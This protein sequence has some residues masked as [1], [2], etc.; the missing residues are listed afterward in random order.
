MRK[1]LVSGLAAFVGLSVPASP[2][3]AAVFSRTGPVIAIVAG[4]IYHGEAEGSLGGTGTITIQSQA[5]PGLSCRGEFTY[6]AE[7]GD[8]GT[9]L[10]N[11]GATATFQFQR[12]S[13][14]RGHG[15]GKSTRGPMS[16]TYGLNAADSLPYLTPPRGKLLQL[17]GKDLV[18][19][20]GGAAAPAAPSEGAAPDV[21]LSAATVAV[22]AGLKEDR[23]LPKRNPAKIAQLVESTILPLFN[24]NHMTQLAVARN[25]RVAS[26]AQQTA[27]VAEFRTLLV[28]TYSNA[29]ENYRDQAVEYRPLHLAAGET[30]VTVKSSV[31]Q[32]GAE[33]LTIDYDMEKTAAGWKVYDIKIAGI[34][35]ITTYQSMF[36]Q[37]VRDEGVEGLIKSL[38][39]KNRQAAA[40]RS[41]AAA[42]RLAA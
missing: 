10:C 4:E 6:S 16:F 3:G 11:D 41:D 15:T 39:E 24:F 28:R 27:L 36:A 23:Q 38:S 29:L 13:V 20:D 22:A 35:L 33:R 25:W 5:K 17:A 26:P 9:M 32:P 30:D 37:T 2:A 19:L 8:A 31:R 42:P 14:M 21:L 1:V 34:S 7:L 40:I 18:L 12:L